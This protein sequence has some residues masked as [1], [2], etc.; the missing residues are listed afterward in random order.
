MKY[1]LLICALFSFT[2]NQA[3]DLRE[4]IPYNATFVG[5]IDGSKIL[6]SVT[7]SELDNSKLGKEMLK[8]FSKESGQE[9]SSIEDIGINTNATTYFYFEKNDSL[10]YTVLLVPLKEPQFLEQAFIHDKAKIMQNNNYKY[11]QADNNSYVAWDNNKMVFV[12]GYSNDEY[13]TD[14]DFSTIETELKEVSEESAEGQVSEVEEVM[15]ATEQPEQ[16]LTYDDLPYLYNYS[17]HLYASNY[18]YFSE[19]LKQAAKNNNSDFLEQLEEQVEQLKGYIAE[20]DSISNPDPENLDNFISNR[21]YFLKQAALS[22]EDPSDREYAQK[23]IDEATYYSDS[24]KVYESPYN[25]DDTSY[26]DHYDEKRVLESK[27]TAYMLHKTMVPAQKSIMKNKQYTAQFDSKAVI[28]IWNSH[29]GNTM[30]EIYSGMYNA[31][32]GYPK[33]LD[34]MMGGYGEFSANLYLEGP[35]ARISVDMELSDEFADIYQRMGNQK[36]NSNFFKYLNEDKLL[37]YMSYNVNFKNTLEEYPRLLAKT[38]GPLMEGKMQDEIAIGADLFSLLLDEE[39]VAKLIKGDALLAF[40]GI[41]EKE[42]TYTDYEYDEDYNYTAVEK[43]KTEKL[44]DFILMASTEEMSLTK[45]IIAYL[46]KKQLVEA[47]NG[48]YKI[49]D[50]KSELPLEVYFAIKNDIFFLTTSASD[51]SDIINDRYTA[52][53]SGKHKKVIKQG[54][55]SAFFNG[56]RFGEAFPVETN[57]PNKKIAEYAVKNASD[58]YL[59]SSKIKNKTMHGE[60]I[61]E[62]PA[63][64]KSTI[65]YLLDFIEH[66]D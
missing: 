41:N 34:E 5:S 53:L 4:H 42:V 47:E 43:T 50:K 22:F 32:Q 19:D 33:S 39:A 21:A 29:L 64:H 31:L 2:F 48:Y 63:N 65:S 35:E 58:F 25:Y 15:E 40:T 11:V 13:F 9:L 1:L 18:Y 12:I 45:N 60:L 66:I 44:P 8:A 54:N 17:L 51:I 36:I 10:S 55:F 59:K 14:Y 30:S 3:Q 27:W 46:V 61:M 16:E 23:L 37:G 62:V 20:I 24:F 26:L 6:E 28:N 52:K 38:Y 56:K 57:M 7:I 49:K